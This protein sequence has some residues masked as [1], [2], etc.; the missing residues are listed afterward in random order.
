[1]LPPKTI[2]LL[3][4]SGKIGLEIRKA[5]AALAL[6]H[7]LLC[8]SRSPWEG[9]VYPQETWLQLDPFATEWPAVGKV[10]VLINAVGAI[11]ETKAMPFTRVHG[12]LTA[13]IL[14]K[15][16]TL[17]QPRIVQIS[18][19]GADA[20]SQSGFLQSKGLA[21]AQLLA[22]PDTVVL[23]PSIVCT[24][25]TMLSQKLRK[26]LTVARFGL[27]KMLVPTGFPHTQIQPIMGA[28]VGIAAAMAALGE[29]NGI[30]DLVGPERID[31][32]TLVQTM[33]KAQGRNVRL[34]EVSREIM[35]TF[36]AH[37][38]GVW[39]PDLI[40]VEQFRLLF[41]DNVGEVAATE[42]LLGRKPGNT[43]PFWEAE[44][45]HPNAAAQTE[46]SEFPHLALA[47]E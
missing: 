34:I 15:R 11:Q 17:G 22:A 14:D 32:A 6:P 16:Q 47:S 31:F 43:I 25:Q 45:I 21:D 27:G 36:V 26:L 44:A 23:R 41:Q 24:P 19:L 42:A 38:V 5:F 4:A 37:F 18:A 7:R 8:C 46:T 1:M 30:I 13:Q 29:Q 40:N 28:D 39:F 35:E 2:L 10:D 33:A 3:G 9:S 20:R 12:G